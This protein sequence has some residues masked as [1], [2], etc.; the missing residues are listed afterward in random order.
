MEQEELINNL[1]EII[2][3]SGMDERQEKA[4][5]KIL[6]GLFGILIAYIFKIFT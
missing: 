6:F 5:I 2:D 1:N 4:L 3:I